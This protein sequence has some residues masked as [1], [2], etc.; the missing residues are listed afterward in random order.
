MAYK[1]HLECQSLG[2]F[3]DPCL[4]VYEP[5]SVSNWSKPALND[6]INPTNLLTQD[7]PILPNYPF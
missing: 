6:K 4:S 1:D 3:P 2:V 5:R 7:G